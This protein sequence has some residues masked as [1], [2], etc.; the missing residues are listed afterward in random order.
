MRGVPFK[1]GDST[2]RRARLDVEA[3]VVEDQR[4]LGRREHGLGEGAAL[5]LGQPVQERAEGDGVNSSGRAGWTG[6]GCSQ[7][8]ASVK[9]A[10][11]RR[12]S[13]SSGAAKFHSPLALAQVRPNS[14]S[15]SDGAIACVWVA[16]LPCPPHWAT[17]LPPG[18]SAARRRAKRRSWSRIQWKVAVEKTK[19]TGSSSSSSTR[20][21]TS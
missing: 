21:A 19:S 20:S 8:R 16:T 13:V 2:R 3:D 14:G 1:A 11:A 17:S 4:A 5:L 6:F 10:A 15:R 18:F 12:A 9:P 7:Q